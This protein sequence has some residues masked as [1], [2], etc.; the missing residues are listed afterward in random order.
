MAFQPFTAR[1]VSGRALLRL[2]VL[3]AIFFIFICTVFLWTHPMRT[4]SSVPT[5]ISH[6]GRPKHPIDTL[7]QKAER[8]WHAIMAKESTDLESA[9][10]A[11]REKRGRNPPPGFD[12][13]FQ[14][15]QDNNALII[16]D[17]FDQIY[18]DLGPFWGVDARK[19]R[20][21]AKNFEQVVS[22]RNGTA[23]MKT[24]KK[25]EWM[26][27]WTNLTATIAEWVPDIDV[28]IN[29]M[30]ES[31]VLVPWED[32]DQYM[33]AERASRRITPKPEVITEYT[34]LQELD[35]N[36]GEAFDPEWH[37]GNHW[38]MARV[39]C[40]PGS[41]S[42]DVEATTN[43]S[44]PPPMPP[45]FPR[46][47][48]EGYVMNW[49]SS[50]DPCLQP[51][52][53]ESHGTFVEPISQSTTKFLFPIFGGSKLPMNNEIL[54]PPAMYWTDDPFYSGGEEQHGGPWENKK[55]GVIWRGTASG[56]RNR[57]ETWTRFQRHRFLTM[58]N[59]TAVQLVEKDYNGIGKNFVVS[60]YST[61]HLTATQYMDL[62]T[63]LD[64][65]TDAAFVHLECFPSNGGPHCPYT[66]HFFQTKAGI[67][68]SKQYAYKYLPDIDGNSFSG[69]YRGF[70]R[71]TSLPI[72]ATIYSEWHDSRLVPWKHFVPMDNSF[73]D[74][75]GI[76]DYFI[77]TD[78][79]KKDR[80]GNKFIEGA[81]D[82]NGRKI[83]M[84][85][86]E[87]AE[88]VLRKEDMQVYVM[89]LYMEYARICDDNREKLGFIG[90]L[91]DFE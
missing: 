91:H 52:L 75:Y 76:L 21:Q 80:E 72:K 15:A 58:I 47:S 86:Q 53:R 36:P 29:V 20:E 6:H 68:M 16:E 70:L 19:I 24:D 27:L 69:R 14:F 18:H 88:R 41:P 77:G 45:G 33:K 11:Y 39:A 78:V 81:H 25:R 9:A 56:G 83:A 57:A 66:D 87:W 71:S 42:R 4:T 26:D 32:I 54:L 49:T 30:D 61:Y 46:H 10:K 44:G 31:R 64:S 1:I 34:G 89:R 62:G 38:D 43:F 37:G 23:T 51:E 74:I 85:G 67:P 55:T 28:P 2:L 17:F 40:A 22:V 35:E 90:D 12:K 63:W 73:V 65:L 8:E 5:I 48:Y 3:L 7:I 50:K 60:S 13:W 79:P 84:D 59:G 82:E